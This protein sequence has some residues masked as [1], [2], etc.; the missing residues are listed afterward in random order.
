[1]RLGPS[2]RISAGMVARTSMADMAGIAAILGR[3]RGDP[4]GLNRATPLRTL[5]WTSPSK[6]ASVVI[7]DSEPD[8]FAPLPPQGPLGLRGVWVVAARC[9]AGTSERSFTCPSANAGEP[10]RRGLH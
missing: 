7:T 2:A 3:C 5:R 10:Q 1:L 6:R 4:A 8:G 9:C